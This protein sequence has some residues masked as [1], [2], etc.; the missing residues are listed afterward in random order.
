MVDIAFLDFVGLVLK[1]CGGEEANWGVVC[2]FLVRYFQLFSIKIFLCYK[3]FFKNT[4]SIK[5]LTNNILSY[6]Q[7]KPISSMGINWIFSLQVSMLQCVCMSEC[8]PPLHFFPSSYILVLG[9]RD[10][11]SCPDQLLKS[12]CLSF[13]KKCDRVFTKYDLICHKYFWMCF[14][15]YYICHSY[16][17]HKSSF[18]QDNS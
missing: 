4:S 10:F 14:K 13:C 17:Q 9:L 7:M 16:I 1:C 15:Y 18:F 8:S 5:S 6:S 3:C 12:S 11:F 2:F